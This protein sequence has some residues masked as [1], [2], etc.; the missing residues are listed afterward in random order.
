LKYE[1]IA[2]GCRCVKQQLSVFYFY[3]LLI[4]PTLTDTRSW[5]GR[6][7]IRLDYQMGS[8][9]Y[10][11]WETVGNDI[12]ILI[13]LEMVRP[14]KRVSQDARVGILLGEASI[15]NDPITLPNTLC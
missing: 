15:I 2:R 12:V 13:T 11:D 8:G 1:I 7:I 6:L 10:N 9:Q 3:S 4:A 5:R 14:R